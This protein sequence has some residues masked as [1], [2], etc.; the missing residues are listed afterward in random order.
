[1]LQGIHFLQSLRLVAHR[2]HV[3]VQLRLTVLDHSRELDCCVDVGED[4]VCRF[5]QQSVGDAQLVQSEGYATAVVAGPF[6]GFWPQ[7]VGGA[8]DFDQV[9]SARSVLPLMRV[10]VDQVSPEH[11]AGDFIVECNRVVAKADGTWRAKLA[12]DFVHERQLG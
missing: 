2:K 8:H 3:R 7:G 4:V 6:E 10:R 5:L 9:P 12:M 1:M 11:E